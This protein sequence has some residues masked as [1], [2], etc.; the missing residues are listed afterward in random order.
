MRAVEKTRAN[1][2]WHFFIFEWYFGKLKLAI[3]PIE[4]EESR[5]QQTRSEQRMHEDS[6]G[7]DR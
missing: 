4:Y 5:E 2:I 6:A 3:E 1:Q 7:V